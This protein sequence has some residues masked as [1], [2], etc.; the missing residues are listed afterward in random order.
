MADLSLVVLAGVP[1]ACII[2]KKFNTPKEKTN[3][4]QDYLTV[5]ALANFKN[6]KVEAMENS[7]F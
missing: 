5:E 3:D 1:T 2:L 7:I 4:F 6:V